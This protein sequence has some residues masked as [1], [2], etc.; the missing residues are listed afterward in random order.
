MNQVN[1]S[2]KLSIF[3]AFIFSQLPLFSQIAHN[4]WIDEQGQLNYSSMDF[5]YAR[6]LVE[7]KLLSGDT[8]HLFEVGLVD[9][10]SDSY[11]LKL[12]DPNSPW[13]TSNVFTKMMFD[14]GNTRVFPEKRGNGYC[15]RLETK[16]RSDNLIGFKV[17]VLLSGTLFLGELIEPVH[18]IKD[19]IKNVSQGIPFN[20]KPKAVKFDYKYQVGKTRIKA[21]NNISEAEG[22]DKA[23]FC[24]I[25]QKRMEDKD[26]NVFATRIGGAREFYS[27]SQIEW[28]NGATYPVFYGDASKLE[29]YDPNTMGL[30][31]SVGK[32]YVKNS[33]GKMMQMTET[34]WGNPEDVPTHMILYFTSS[35]QGI[36]YIGSTESV[37]WVDNIE[38]VY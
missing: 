37:F 8:I 18:G 32:V 17:D 23:E 9:T 26:G 5:W 13:G 15:C 35:Y 16:I 22:E 20:L 30:I 27:D 21:A 36:E 3:I 11:N 38:F 29:Q 1:T 31:P 4:E 2:L 14:I 12:K 33:K 6:N 7:S 10:V 19:P 25:L 34:G 28:V 24:V